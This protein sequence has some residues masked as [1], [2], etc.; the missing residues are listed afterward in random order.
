MKIQD[1]CCQGLIV[2][3]ARIRRMVDAEIAATML[4]STASPARSGHV[5]F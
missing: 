5:H 4:R 1:W 3:S 2:S